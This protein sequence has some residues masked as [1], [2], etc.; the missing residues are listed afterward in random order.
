MNNQ[1]IW[2]KLL[3]EKQQ[4]KTSLFSASF[5]YFFEKLNLFYESFHSAA[6]LS[7]LISSKSVL[8]LLLPTFSCRK[9]HETPTTV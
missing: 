2:E 7:I 8:C 9:I 6:Q 4:E 3:L 1:N 5:A